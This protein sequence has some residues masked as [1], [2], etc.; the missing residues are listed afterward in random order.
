MGRN[1]VGNMAPCWKEFIA[2]RTRWSDSGMMTAVFASLAI[3]AGRS[4]GLLIWSCGPKQFYIVDQWT[5]ASD[6][7]MSLLPILQTVD[8]EECIKK[9]HR[10]VLDGDYRGVGEAGRVEGR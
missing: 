1:L 2:F 5:E 6:T 10:F 4:R 7:R 9:V 8:C 3:M